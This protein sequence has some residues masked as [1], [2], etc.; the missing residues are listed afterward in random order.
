MRRRLLAAFVAL[1]GLCVLAAPLLAPALLPT[2][3]PTYVEVAGVCIEEIR[4]GD[5]DLEGR[6]VAASFCGGA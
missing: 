3:E 5:G 1:D 2:P 4:D 6:I